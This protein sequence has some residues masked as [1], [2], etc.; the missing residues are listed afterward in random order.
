MTT[1]NLLI[2]CNLHTISDVRHVMKF[3]NGYEFFLISKE[4]QKSNNYGV[5]AINLVVFS[6][7]TK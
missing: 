1:L 3:V 5:N 4:C 2:N 6:Q 7:L